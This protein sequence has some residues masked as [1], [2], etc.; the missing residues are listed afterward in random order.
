VK[1]DATH[2]ED[3]ATHFDDD[4]VCPKKSKIPDKVSS[5]KRF[6]KINH[7]DLTKVNILFHK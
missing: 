6:K 7:F 2:F 1:R 3:D 4:P 5:P